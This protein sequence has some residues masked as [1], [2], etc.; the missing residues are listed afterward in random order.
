[1]RASGKYNQAPP[2]YHYRG[3]HQKGWD[4]RHFLLGSQPGSA[5]TRKMDV[6][7]ARPFS[8]SR[9]ESIDRSRAGVASDSAVAGG[10]G[11]WWMGV[12]GR[13]GVE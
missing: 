6:A 4:F 9:I 8:R 3:F 10:D 13:Q 2:I 11:G 7:G 12:A 5:L 1:M